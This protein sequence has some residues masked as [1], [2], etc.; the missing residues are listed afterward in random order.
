MG[1]RSSDRTVVP[2]EPTV[3]VGEPQETLQGLAVSGS[4]PL[5]YCPDLLWVHAD[6]PGRDD[7]SQ[8]GG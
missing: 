4:G 2:D 8:K 5:L 7:V 6:V 3:E 1:E